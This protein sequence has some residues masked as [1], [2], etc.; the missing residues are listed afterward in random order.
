MHALLPLLALLLAPPSWAQDDEEEL[1]IP[2]DEP[3]LDD[4][5]SEEDDYEF[6]ADT[7]GDT[8]LDDMPVEPAYDGPIT[9]ILVSEFQAI[10]S[11]AAGFAALLRLF[12]NDT[13]DAR[14]ELR[15]IPVED[16]P[17]FGE[18]SAQ[19]YLESCPPGRPDRLRLGRRQAGR[20]RLRPHRRGRGPLRRHHPGQRHDHRCLRRPG[21]A[22]L[23]RGARAG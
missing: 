4:D 23:R 15:G 13:L 1:E 10:N 7:T 19:V 17:S 5:F 22:V 18:H 12:L 9:P 14:P 21:G 8:P 11:D 2:P 3:R 20:G 6:D 16:V